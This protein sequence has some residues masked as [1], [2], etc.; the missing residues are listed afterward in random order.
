VPTTRIV[1]AL[2]YRNQ[3]LFQSI[4]HFVLSKA[5]GVTDYFKNSPVFELGLHHVLANPPG[6]WNLPDSSISRFTEI[7]A[8]EETYD[9]LDLT[10][11]HHIILGMTSVG[12][13][14]QLELSA[15]EINRRRMRRK[16]PPDVGRSQ[17][18][19]QKHTNTS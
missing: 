19:Y 13:A 12:L 16:N 1:R 6:H 2:G 10:S 3:L 17:R 14:T 9:K 4:V 7:F 18:R 15:A 8:N 11:L 5:Q